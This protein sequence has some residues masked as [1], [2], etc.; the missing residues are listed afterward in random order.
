MPAATKGIVGVYASRRMAA[1]LLLGFSSGLPLALTGDALAAWLKDAN[2]DVKTIG[3]LSLVALPYSLK[4]IWSPAM[5]R[6]AIPLLGRRRGWLLLTQLALMVA[7]LAMSLAGQRPSL[8][9]VAFVASAVAL[10]SA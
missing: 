10:L 2:Y 1:L 5:D 4:F 9:V 6:F 3:L 7:I 8:S